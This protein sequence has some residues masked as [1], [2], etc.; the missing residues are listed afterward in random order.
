M[1]RSVGLF[2]GSTAPECIITGTIEHLE[3][4]DSG[5]SV[6]IDVRV[7]AGLVDFQTGAVLW[8]GS[9]S[10][11]AVVEERSISGVVSQLSLGLGSAVQ[12]L[13]SSMQEH[14]ASFPP[15]VSRQPRPSSSNYP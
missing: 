2:D 6:S 11:D 4:V 10:H 5:N 1:A 8:R 3:E 13:V 9:A 12:E 7:S 14:L 15:H